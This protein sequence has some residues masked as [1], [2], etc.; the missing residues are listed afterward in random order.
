MTLKIVRK[1]CQNLV[2]FLLIL[3]IH[4]LLHHPS[5]HQLL[6]SFLLLLFHFLST[7][8]SSAPCLIINNQG[9]HWGNDYPLSIIV[10]GRLCCH[11]HLSWLTQWSLRVC[12]SYE[13]KDL[14]KREMID[15]SRFDGEWIW[16]W[17][18]FFLRDSEVIV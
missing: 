8:I 2:V 3:L 11:Q 17:S 7:S 9:V 16:E 14:R 18:L 10:F 13:S 5:L 12:F 6:V 1:S 15:L 4:L